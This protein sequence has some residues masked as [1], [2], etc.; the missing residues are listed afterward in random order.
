MIRFLEPILS[1]K[2]TGEFSSTR[3]DFVNSCRYL[4][5]AKCT[6]ACADCM[7]GHVLNI[8][9]D[10]KLQNLESNMSCRGYTHIIASLR[11]H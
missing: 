3:L 11:T 10:G 6:D 5:H 7:K 9:S 8:N 2:K 1:G 4:S